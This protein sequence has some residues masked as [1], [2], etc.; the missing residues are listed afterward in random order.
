MT[1]ETTDER[2]AS[3]EKG[4]KCEDRKQKKKNY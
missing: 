2:A 3:L 4:N 1:K